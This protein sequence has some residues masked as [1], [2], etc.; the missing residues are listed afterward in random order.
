MDQ[1]INW[2]KIIGY[3]NYEVSDAG[4]VRN[5]T[6]GRVL[7][8]G[9]DTQGYYRISLCK[10][11][12]AKTICLHRLVGTV[13]IVNPDNKPCIDHID[14]NRTNNHLTNLRWATIKEN[15]MNAKIGK[16]NTS[17]IKGVCFHK[18]D[19]RWTARIKIDGININIGSYKTI[20]EAQKARIKKANEVF[21]V[22]TNAC[23]KL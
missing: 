21:G 7:K 9:I 5:S 1:I 20:E 6:T 17:G 4:D 15:N 12:K 19:N 11:G 3:E 16:N 8:K 14:N 13:F 23:E 10:N 18:R 22:Y 2:K